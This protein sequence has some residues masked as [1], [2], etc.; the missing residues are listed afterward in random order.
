MPLGK[1]LWWHFKKI[2]LVFSYFFSF[3]LILHP[4]RKTSDNLHEHSRL[5]AA[6]SWRS[7]GG[8][9]G[10]RTHWGCCYLGHAGYECKGKGGIALFLKFLEENDQEHLI[11]VKKEKDSYTTRTSVKAIVSWKKLTSVSDLPGWTHTARLSP[12]WHRKRGRES[13]WLGHRQEKPKSWLTGG[14]LP[15]RLHA[16]GFS[17]WA[18]TSE[19]HA[20]T[21]WEIKP[22]NYLRCGNQAWKCAVKTYGSRSN[23]R[24]F[25]H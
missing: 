5:M 13:V 15:S 19:H 24:S 6:G 16:K 21:T 8:D 11:F 4:H 23:Q 18:A 22:E 17:T 25:K 1:S 10:T 14:Q 7:R 9:H 20:E 2:V 3:P 12:R